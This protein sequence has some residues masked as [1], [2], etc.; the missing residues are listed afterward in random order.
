MNPRTIAMILTLLLAPALYAQTAQ[1]VVLSP[2]DAQAAADLYTQRAAID[3]KIN[4]LKDVLK[5]KY[6]D[7][8]CAAEKNVGFWC[9][10]QWASGFE[11]STDFKAIVPE[12]SQA[13]SIPHMMPNCQCLGTSCECVGN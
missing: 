9:G 2:A 8:V 6:L 12:E 1:V 10:S 3:T 7:P 4:A 13:K 11:F 5:V